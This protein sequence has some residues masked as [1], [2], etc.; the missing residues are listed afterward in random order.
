MTV[1]GSSVGSRSAA[2]KE[3]TINPSETRYGPCNNTLMLRIMGGVTSH[4][5]SSVVKTF[6][7]LYCALLPGQ[8]ELTSNSYSVAGSKPLRAYEF[9]WTLL[10]T[11]QVTSA[12]RRQRRLKVVT[13]SS[14]AQDSNALL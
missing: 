14:S 2:R 8:A 1:Y 10:T 12:V 6:G 4:G 5:S 3:S 9:A 13:T 7:P 11:V